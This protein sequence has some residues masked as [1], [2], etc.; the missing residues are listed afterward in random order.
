[1]S[2]MTSKSFH[3][4]LR[5]YRPL[6]NKSA[7]VSLY[8]EMKQNLALMDSQFQVLPSLSIPPRQPRSFS[9]KLFARGAGIWLGQG[10]WPKGAVIIYDRGWGRREMVGNWKNGVC[11]VGYEKILGTK[12][13]G[14]L[15]C[16]TL[17][18]T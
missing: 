7:S 2:T 10:I 3:D 17:Y 5:S 13:L 8:F 12:R 16:S 18:I 4:E 11:K 1:M 6:K 9:P 15:F 14:I